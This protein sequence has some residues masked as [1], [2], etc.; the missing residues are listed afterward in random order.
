MSTVKN[1]WQQMDGPTQIGII[2]ATIGII[3]TIVGIIRD[4]TTPV[5]LWSLTVGCL[6]TGI[7]WGTVSWA[8]AFA[9]VE[10]EKDVREVE[11]AR[12]SHDKS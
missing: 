6:I 12:E 9:A 8:I 1:I 3:L 10:V 4:P 7:V 11:I 2:C 5:T